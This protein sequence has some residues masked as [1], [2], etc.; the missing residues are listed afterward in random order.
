MAALTITQVFGASATLSAGTLTI[1]LADFTG[2]GLD[3]AT[4]K[5]SSILS[6]LIINLKSIQ[7]STASEDTDVGVVVGDKYRMIARNDT[8]LEEQYPVSIYRPIAITDLDPDE[9]VG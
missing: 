7:S 9:V 8:Q 4:T 3:P 1:D 5:A 2:T 6:A